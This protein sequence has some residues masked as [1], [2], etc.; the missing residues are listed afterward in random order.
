MWEISARLLKRDNARRSRGLVLGATFEK[1]NKH[2]GE[3]QSHHFRTF[4]SFFC[5]CSC[6]TQLNG[7]L[8][9]WKIQQTKHH[10]AI[11][12]ALLR[13]RNYCLQSWRRMKKSAHLPP[14][15]TTLSEAALR[16]WPN[17]WHTKLKKNSIPVIECTYGI[18]FLLGSRDPAR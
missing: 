17:R 13:K 7:I 4:L 3:T 10:E 1:Q 16:T 18:N 14:F 8:M 11:R 6:I 12:A 9:L 2:G 5:S 15:L